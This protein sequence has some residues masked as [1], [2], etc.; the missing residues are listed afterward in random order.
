LIVLDTHVWLWWTA[1]PK[2]LSRR[3]REAIERTDRVGISAISC[4]E[5]AT[6]ARLGRIQ[7]DRPV[8]TW[9]AQALAQER[10]SALRVSDRIA[11]HAGLLEHFPGDPADRLI[12][13]TALAEGAQLATKDRALR[14][15]DRERTVW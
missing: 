4:W 8:E 14:S 1:S 3:V 5:V 13:A 7:L 10:A 6:L 15:F 12:Y 11:V 9:V 2:K